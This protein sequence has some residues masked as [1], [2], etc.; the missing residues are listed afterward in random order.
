[1]RRTAASACAESIARCKGVFPEGE[2]TNLLSKTDRC[3]TGGSTKKEVTLPIRSAVFRRSLFKGVD[4]S[5]KSRMKPT[6]PVVA[7]RCL[8]RTNNVVG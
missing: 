3:A 7:A 5:I 6:D 4:D 2:E 1:M 8:K